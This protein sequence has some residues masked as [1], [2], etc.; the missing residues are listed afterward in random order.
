MAEFD[1]A[2]M[3]MEVSLVIEKAF[4]NERSTK[5][6]CNWLWNWR[7]YIG[8]CALYCTGAPPWQS[9]W[10]ADKVLTWEALYISSLLEMYASIN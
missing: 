3:L 5:S 6:C 1:F 8:Q 2:L 7:T 10:P 9:K 4:N